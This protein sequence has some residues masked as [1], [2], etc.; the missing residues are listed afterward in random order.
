MCCI[1]DRDY[2]DFIDQMNRD[3]FCEA[4]V[5]YFMQFLPQ[6]RKYIGMKIIRAIL[7]QPTS[8]DVPFGVNDIETISNLVNELRRRFGLDLDAEC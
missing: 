4:F 2:Q 7:D 6:D 3:K 5:K 8:L 1:K